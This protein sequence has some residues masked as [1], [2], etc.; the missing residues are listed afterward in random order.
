MA[1]RLLSTVQL[2][3][4]NHMILMRLYT[5]AE[6]LLHHTCSLCLPAFWVSSHIHLNF[7]QPFC[8][9]DLLQ[10]SNTITCDKN[11]YLNFESVAMSQL[12]RH[13][14]TSTCTTCRL[15]MSS[16][17]NKVCFLLDLLS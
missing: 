7:H 8:F 5:P 10:F 16:V 3:Y 12:C 6:H 1:C 17:K 11:I 15:T 4:C 13:I 2:Y 14:F 9:F